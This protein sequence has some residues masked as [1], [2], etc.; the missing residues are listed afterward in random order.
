LGLDF[1]QNPPGPA[2]IL[3]PIAPGLRRLIA[4]NPGPFT[5]TGTCSYVVGHGEITVI[6]PGPEDAGH[7][8]ALLAQTS[9]ERIGAIL[10]THTHRD[11]SPGAKLLQTRTG[12]P[13]FGCA[14]HKAARPLLSDEINLLDASADHAYRPQRILL[15]GERVE[16]GDH[17]FIAI[18]TPGHTINHLAFEWV[19]SGMVFSGDHVMAWSTSIVAPPDGAMG[20]YLAS[21]EKFI[22]RGGDQLY[23]P[24]HGGPVVEP[25]RF[26]RA[27]LSHRRQRE[28]QIIATLKRQ[29]AYIPELVG[30][31]Y[32][33]LAAHLKGAAGLSVFAHLEDLC[34]RRIVAS[35]GPPIL[36]ARYFLCDRAAMNPLSLP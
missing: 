13:I 27:L 23:W 20:P 14:P 1:D 12:A 4:P 25:Q 22:A 17:A 2:G 8:D 7:I 32:P 11:H 26:T 34:A 31:H 24:G 21:L 19:G 36:S 16:V 33:G 3:Q 29:P 6:D 28:A 10:I 30:A 15:E 18:E 5:F 9:G 35:E